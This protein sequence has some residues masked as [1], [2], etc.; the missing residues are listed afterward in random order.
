MV[1]TQGELLETYVSPPASAVNNNNS[2]RCLE[3]QLDLLWEFV[4]HVLSVAASCSGRPHWQI[5]IGKLGEYSRNERTR[6]P[7]LFISSSRSLL[8]R[9]TYSHTQIGS[10][11][12]PPV[13]DHQATSTAKRLLLSLLLPWLSLAASLLSAFSSTTRCSCSRLRI[14]VERPPVS[15]FS[16]L[17]RVVTMEHRSMVSVYL[18]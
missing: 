5:V 1:D 4:R 11:S 14:T 8:D 15:P 18:R 9:L 12:S 7:S 13:C 2:Y 10:R 16:P 17:K 3:Q 6:K